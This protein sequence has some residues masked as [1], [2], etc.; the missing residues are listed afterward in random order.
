MCQPTKKFCSCADDAAE[1]SAL[2]LRTRSFR[3]NW[4]SQLVRFTRTATAA[5]PIPSQLVYPLHRR[6]A[7][8][9]PHHPMLVVGLS[10]AKL[11]R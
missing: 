8:S 3:T 2:R 11:D 4:A 6:P 10:H 5:Y 1:Q 7:G 9:H